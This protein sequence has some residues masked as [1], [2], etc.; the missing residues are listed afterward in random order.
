M[1]LNKSVDFKV[2]KSLY[3]S[4]LREVELGYIKWGDDFNYIENTVLAS[5]YNKYSFRP[6][7]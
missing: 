6:K 3:A 7:S 1:Y 2:I 4:I 5:S